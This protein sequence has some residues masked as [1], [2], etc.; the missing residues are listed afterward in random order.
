MGSEA[1]KWGINLLLNILL[2]QTWIPIGGVYFA[3]NS[4]AWYLSLT[5]FF[6][7]ISSLMVKLAEKM[8]SGIIILVI[9]VITIFQ[10]FLVHVIGAKS[11]THW[12][13]Y[14][15]PLTRSLD[16]LGGGICV[17]VEKG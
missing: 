13:V 12:A 1:W 14:I 6:V 9:T 7:L 8:R 17:L 10:F 11:W 3:F 5:M 4:V 15:C 16:F 2:L